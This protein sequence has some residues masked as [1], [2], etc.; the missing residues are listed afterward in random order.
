MT[1]A[2]SRFSVRF[3]VISFV[4]LAALPAMSYGQDN[5][6]LSAVPSDCWAMITVSNLQE[7]DAKGAKLCRSLGVPPLALKTLFDARLQLGPEIPTDRPIGVVFMPAQSR[8]TIGPSAVLLLPCR[9]VSAW[10]GNVEHQKLADQLWQAQLV[11]GATFVAQRNDF[12]VVGTTEAATRRVLDSKQ[13]LID[14]L[15]AD[16]R[17]AISGSDIAVWLNTQS[18]LGSDVFSDWLREPET[19]AGANSPLNMNA[20]VFRK[21]AW[22]EQTKTA[23]LT[24]NLNAARLLVDVH[25]ELVPE[26][27]MAQLFSFPGSMEEKA[28]SLLPD[29]PYVFSVAAQVTPEQMQAKAEMVDELFN[30]DAIA[31]QIDSEHLAALRQRLSGLIADVRAAQWGLAVLPE[32]PEGS[33]CIMGAVR[34]NNA[35]TWLV[36]LRS[37]VEIIHKSFEKSL[38]SNPYFKSISYTQ[39]AD[40][41]QAAPI[42]HLTIDWADSS[43]PVAESAG[44][45]TGESADKPQPFDLMAALGAAGSTIQLAA[46]NDHWL[47]IC[48]AG[49][50]R[51]MSVLVQHLRDRSAGL[52]RNPAVVQT[53]TFLPSHV[54]FAAACWPQAWVQLGRI[55]ARRQ[56]H[57]QAYQTDM[58]QL[59]TPMMAAMKANGKCVDI[60]LA[61]PVDL[62]VALKQAYFGGESNQSELVPQ[63]T[64]N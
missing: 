5:T 8:E 54:P 32:S 12:A 29:Q 25:I 60:Q 49:H 46:I 23:L 37:A 58:L 18:I 24:F 55:H 36:N 44:A 1:Y 22:L 3:W 10:L 59:N 14:V 7:L 30:S 48:V 62:L 47:A 2:T 45:G 50:P 21:R 53:Q 42:D 19:S 27:K 34:V 39:G 38:T 56:Q 28:F 51:Q 16:Q 57:P 43:S 13:L 4:L 41:I 61:I 11:W 64:A 52:D 6:I 63:S 35:E 26:S 9:D 20:L 40:E 15:T 17:T 31:R 33:A